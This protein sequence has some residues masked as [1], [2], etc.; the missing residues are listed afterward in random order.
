MKIGQSKKGNSSWFGE[1]D[2]SIAIYLPQ[3]SFIV[4]EI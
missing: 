3:T 1:T 4:G 2:M